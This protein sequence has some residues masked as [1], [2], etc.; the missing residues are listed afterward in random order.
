MSLAKGTIE[1]PDGMT[2][3]IYDELMVIFGAD[4]INSG[5]EPAVVEKGFKKL[6]YAIASGVIKH[7][8]SN[9]SISGITTNA[10]THIQNND[11][12]GRVS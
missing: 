2:K 10:T 11:G 12:M 3:D 8:T 5:A 1:A 6:S 4:L 7:V 9:M